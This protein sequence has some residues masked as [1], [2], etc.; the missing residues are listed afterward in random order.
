MDVTTSDTGTMKST[1]RDRGSILVLAMVLTLVL[2]FV[3]IAIARYATVGLATSQTTS[4]RTR[5]NAAASAAL[6]WAID[7][8]AAKRLYPGVD[9]TTADT[10]IAVPAAALP[11]GSVTL[12]CG[13]SDEVGN[14]PTVDLT[15]IATVDGVTRTID[16]L[17]QVPRDTYNA[18]IR[19]WEPG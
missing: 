3:T 9:C 18:Q 1:D 15:A 17:L 11:Y 10:T 16:V 8:F 2:A 6:Q 5:S 4:H 19:S 12:T 14:H 7:E 13:P